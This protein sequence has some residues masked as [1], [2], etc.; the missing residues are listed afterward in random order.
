VRTVYYAR[1]YKLHTIAEM[2][3]H[4]SIKLVEVPADNPAPGAP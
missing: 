1:P 2:L 4:A 3:K